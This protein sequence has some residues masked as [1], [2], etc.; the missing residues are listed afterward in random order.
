[1]RSHSSSGV[2]Q[3]TLLGQALQG[4]QAASSWQQNNYAVACLHNGQFAAM[5]PSSSVR[6]ADGGAGRPG[7]AL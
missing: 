5:G 7:S 2:F 1:M 4:R 6:T 3:K